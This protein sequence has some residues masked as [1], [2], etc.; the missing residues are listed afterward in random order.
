MDDRKKQDEFWDS[1]ENGGREQEEREV[2][3]ESGDYARDNMERE[4]AERSN[5]QEDFSAPYESFKQDQ[6]TDSE[7]EYRAR[8]LTDHGYGLD[9]GAHQPSDDLAAPPRQLHPFVP[10]SFAGK[11]EQRGKGGGSM[12]RTA[13]VSFL[14][15]VLAISGLFWTMRTDNWLTGHHPLTAFASHGGHFQG[16]GKGHFAGKPGPSYSAHN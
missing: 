5:P 2:R 11:E 12:F 9:A 1:S 15:G 7:S 10:G 16:A 13:A 3:Q 6:S 4:N 14:A 8:R